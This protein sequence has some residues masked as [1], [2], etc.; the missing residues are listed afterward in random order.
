MINGLGVDNAEV[1][2]VRL[3]PEG[4]CG[5]R[6]IETVPWFP[7]LS[8][9]SV[10]GLASL[11]NSGWFVRFQWECDADDTDGTRVRRLERS[12]PGMA[13]PVEGVPV[14]ARGR[15]AMDI[16]GRIPLDMHSQDG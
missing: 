3:P 5:Y 16:A 2:S 8:A 14:S 10:V 11:E 13:Y 15:I 6:K 4:L 1:V 12:C 7:V 9:L